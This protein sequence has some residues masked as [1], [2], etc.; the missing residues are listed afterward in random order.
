MRHENVQE[1]SKFYCAVQT[2]RLAYTGG[3]GL[4]PTGS[5]E[6][7]HEIYVRSIEPLMGVKLFY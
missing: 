2:S 6:N 1:I 5:W 7:K 3:S 4:I